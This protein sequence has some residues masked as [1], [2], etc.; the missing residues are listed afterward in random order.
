MSPRVR[1]MLW[2]LCVALLLGGQVVWLFLLRGERILID[3]RLYA[4]WMS[5]SLVVLGLWWLLRT[6]PPDAVRLP[7]RKSRRVI[8]L[9]VIVLQGCAI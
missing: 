8:L 9:G 7:V 4:G 3:P 1:F 5:G 6:T 2:I